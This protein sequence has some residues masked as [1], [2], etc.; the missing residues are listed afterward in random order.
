MGISIKNEETERL[1]R[2]LARETGESLTAAIRRAL[3]DRL[4]RL[5]RRRSPAQ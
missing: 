2:V 3:E 4:A 1:A 5:E